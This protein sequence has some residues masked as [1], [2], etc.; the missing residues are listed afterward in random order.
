MGGENVEETF[1]RYDSGEGADRFLI[2][3]REKFIRNLAAS[4][5]WIIDGTFKRSPDIFYQV[6][7]V[8]CRFRD[9]HH[10]YP[11]MYILMPNKTQRRYFEVFTQVYFFL[12]LNLCI[13]RSFLSLARHPKKSAVTMSRL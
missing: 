7:V 13:C 5:D 10:V 8:A 9:T 6:M 12:A 11:A 4:R 1:L 2:F 3:G